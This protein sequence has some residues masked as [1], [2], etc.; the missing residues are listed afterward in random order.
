MMSA[1]DP[2][3]VSLAK[4]SSLTFGLIRMKRYK[5]MEKCFNLVE[6]LLAGGGTG[7]RQALQT[8]FIPGLHE[9]LSGCE[10]KQEVIARLPE[11]LK[12]EYSRHSVPERIRNDYVHFTLHLN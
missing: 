3:G 5:Q 7:V 8:G 4:L 2:F 10:W 9:V 6:H 11:Q 1:R 12:K